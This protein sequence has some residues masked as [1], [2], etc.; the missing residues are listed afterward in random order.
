M[1]VLL[2]SN[3]YPRKNSDFGIFIKD[4]VE[5]LEKNGIKMIKVVKTGKTHFAYVPFVSKS[6]FYLLFRTYDLVHGHYGF[7]SALFPAVIKRKPLVVTFHGS[8]ALKEPLRHKVYRSLQ[9]FII[10]RSD[11]IIAVSD[12]IKNVLT[13]NLGAEPNRISII[14]CAVD[15]SVFVSLEKMDVRRKLGIAQ[16]A[17]VV[18]FAGSL[19]YTKG[20][21]VIFECAQRMPDVLFILVGDG[22]LKTGIKNCKFPGACPHE[23]MPIWMNAADIFVLPSRSE[24]TPVVILEALSCG[25]P[26]IASRIGGCPDVIKDGQTGYLVPVNDV[27]ILQRKLRDLLNDEVGRNLMGR[28]GRED[29]MEKF[30]NK[31]ITQS[32]KRIYEETINSKSYFRRV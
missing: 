28:R 2:I 12:E 3:M 10:S 15:T 16:N 8:D 26:V 20:V 4:Q 19:S 17:K 6:I 32:I 25:I 1:Q 14:S 31:K 5:N 21:D 30:D 22:L 13:S 11:N 29:M 23:E 9:K 18:L 24:G 27:D 7:H